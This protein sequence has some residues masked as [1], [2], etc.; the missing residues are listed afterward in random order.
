MC[1]RG[2]RVILRDGSSPKHFSNKI[3]KFKKFNTQCI[4]TGMAGASLSH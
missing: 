2:G 3:K 4:K 1:G